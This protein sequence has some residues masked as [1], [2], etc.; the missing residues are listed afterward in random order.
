VDAY[1]LKEPAAGRER[2][3]IAQPD[4]CGRLE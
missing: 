2:L 1:R 4:P 3:L